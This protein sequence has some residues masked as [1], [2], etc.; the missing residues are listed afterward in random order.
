MK[1]S[2]IIKCCSIHKALSRILSD[3]RH[4]GFTYGNIN[5]V[6]GLFHTQEDGLSGGGVRVKVIFYVKVV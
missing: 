1:S 5:F 3:S 4:S 2:N 6:Q